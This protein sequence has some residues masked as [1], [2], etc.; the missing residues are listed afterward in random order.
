[1][2]ETM[3]APAVKNVAAG[4]PMATGGVLVAPLGTV[5]PTDATTALAE[6]AVGLGYI[7][8]DGLTDSG[9][10]SSDKRRAWGG[11]IVLVSQTEFSQ[12]YQFTLIE[13]KNGDVLKVVYGDDN[14]TVTEATA[15]HG[16][17]HAVA[18]NGEELPHKV[19]IFEINMGKGAKRRIVVP[20]A[21]VTEVGERTY[22]DGTEVSY[23]VTIEAFED[24]SGNNAYQYDDDGVLDAA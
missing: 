12:T 17:R 16:T 13:S 20:N 6:A 11:D 14:V 15:T 7:S 23:P 2:E 4:K 8:E 21:Q 5:L 1:M 9:E 19:F 10:R 3:A 18:V 24:A 22:V